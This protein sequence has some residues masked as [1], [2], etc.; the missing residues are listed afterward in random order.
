MQLL[1]PLSPPLTWAQ[2][3]VSAVDPSQPYIAGGR[4]LVSMSFI[5]VYSK[6]MRRHPTA[7]GGYSVKKC[8]NMEYAVVPPKGANWI[9]P[10]FRIFSVA[11]SRSDSPE[12]HAV[13]IAKRSEIQW[14]RPGGGAKTAENLWKA[15]GVMVFKHWYEK[16]DPKKDATDGFFHKLPF[17]TLSQVWACVDYVRKQSNP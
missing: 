15:W 5:Q 12:G 6:S 4:T 10:T 9:T 8:K 16:E 1:R 3:A 2:A 7:C 14:K 17:W 11:T 13:R